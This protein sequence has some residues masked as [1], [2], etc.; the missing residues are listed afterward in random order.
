MA[1]IPDEVVEQVR[2]AADLLEIIQEHVQLK[3]TGSDWR[4]PC[5]FHQ[6][7]GRNFAVIPR[8]NVYY[9]FVCH[10]SG[11]VFTWY[12]E[13]LGL[14]YP[15]AVREVARRYGIVVPESTERAGP[16]P[17]EPLFQACD[18]AQGWF[19]AQ[20]RDNPEAETARRYLLQRDFSL[21]A[22]ATLG[23]GYA[24]RGNEF[25]AAMTQ[26]GIADDVLVET[27]LLVRREDGSTAPRFRG[28][29]LFP[30]HDLRARVVGFGGRILGSGEPKYLN[31]SE[32]AIFHK[33]EQLYHMHVARNA[34]RKAEYAVLVEGYFDVQR[35]ALAG[36]EQVVAP[37]GTSLTEAQATLLK[38]FTNDVVVLYDSDAPGLKAT[39]RA[40]DTL[41]AHGIQVR[42]ATLPPGD[43]P[44]TLVQRGG[45][46]AVEQVLADAVDVLE[47]KL[48]LLD[49]KGW[50]G[51]VGRAREALD[52]LLPTVRATSDAVTREL[53]VSR[54]AERLG[55]PRD[56]VAAEVARKASPASTVM[57]RAA[58]L[59]DHGIDQPTRS[60]R[61]G[62]RTPGAEIERKLMRLVLLN[63]QWLARAR[64]EVDPA[65]LAVPAYRAIF[66]AVLALPADAP[67]GD[68]LPL[69]DER[70]RDVWARL[71]ER[72]TP[73]EGYDLDREYAGALEALDEIHTFADIAAEDDPGQRR[74][75]WN[76]LS[77]EGQA[78]FR[79]YLANSSSRRHA[80]RDAPL[81]E[82]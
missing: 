72:G 79:L 26:L 10:A 78:R 57:P 1:R 39:F 25:R 74:R 30:I 75:R 73:G 56:A 65:R 66:E 13:R 49:R 45:L 35:L 9:C 67:I 80:D 64:D 3:R 82:E 14:D 31:S 43:D 12:R 32:S 53:Y 81:V 70:T 16:D 8:K 38:R 24:P 17:R 28:R 34:I 20:L 29:L 37:L 22:A 62:A 21:D 69:L 77:K 58:P 15:S 55:I 52:R 50:F 36:M 63:P 4:G 76:A 59:P 41:L 27:S 48:Q 61:P 60:T 40:A 44:D 33:G 71:V 19:A 5:P 2:D 11:D 68:A 42:V 54:L 51:D 23:L 6:G 47:R 18:A 7:T 46:A